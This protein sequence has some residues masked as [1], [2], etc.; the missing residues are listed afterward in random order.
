MSGASAI[1]SARRRRSEPPALIT[2]Q[3]A[4]N[5]A[6]VISNDITPKQPK[7]PLEILRTHEIK[8]AQIE[9]S[10]DEK[11]IELSKIVV[12]E[13]LKHL[14]QE[15][16]V[17][18]TG[19]NLLRDDLSASI[20]AVK[21]SLVENINASIM[22]VKDSLVEIINSSTVNYDELKTIVIK[23]QQQ[24]LETNTEMLKM[25]DRQVFLENKI[26]ELETM[27]G[28]RQCDGENNLFNMDEG[29]TAEMLLRSMMQTSM[30]EYDESE[31][32][33]IHDNEGEGDDDDM[34]KL[35]DIDEI[36]LTESD[37]DSIKNNTHEE[38]IDISD[39]EDDHNEAVEDVEDVEAVE[40]VEAVEDVE[41]VK[42]VEDVEDVEA[43]KSAPSTGWMEHLSRG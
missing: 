20:T 13:N 15:I 23:N 16:E 22:T 42:A 18:K 34:T 37:L 41:A 7:P 8:I 9:E 33:N 10:F 14:I 2:P 27:V 11:I 26:V 17:I 32:L 43:A 5:Q 12:H 28:D 29:G 3:N 24:S 19:N 21:D 31:I 40:A 39:C 38:L 6:T 36:K 1:A 4:T 35:Y 25:K 30:A